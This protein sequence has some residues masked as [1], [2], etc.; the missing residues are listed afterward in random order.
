MGLVLPIMG[1]LVWDDA[2]TEESGGGFVVIQ[3]VT[4]LRSPL[5]ARIA[6]SR[7]SRP[8]PFKD[9]ASSYSAG[10]ATPTI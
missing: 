1:V 2:V 8:K 10:I 4:G 6:L 9:K 7:V 5:V 3:L